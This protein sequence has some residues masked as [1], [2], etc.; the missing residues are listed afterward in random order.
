MRR[1]RFVLV[2]VL[3]AAAA[4]GWRWTSLEPSNERAW[5]PQQARL[6]L[7]DFADSSVRVRGIRNFAY[8]AADSFTAGYYDRSYD[9]R[10]LES[11]WF[12]VVPFSKRWRGPAH[13]FVSFGFS[14]SQYV[15]ISVEARR[16]MGETY[17]TLAGLFRRYELMYVVGD[18]RDVIG[19]R[20][21]F[22]ADDVY[23]YPIR[24]PA[25]SVRR[26]FVEMLQR[27]NRLH[28]APEF[29]NTLTNS[30]TSNVVRHVNRVAPGRVPAG[31]KTILPGYSDEVAL[32]LGLIDTELD[33]AGA[34]RRFQIN[35]RARRYLADSAFSLRIREAAPGSTH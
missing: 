35:A 18:E 1:S 19:Q 14:D 34:R 28:E 22:G 33:L 12:I 25:A 10:R 13:T 16:E 15:A 23:L 11:A 20:A 30:C 26:V 29:Y 31:I 6:A 24:A 2:V 21:A 8:V 27:V 3:G 32:K 5:V 9:L 17:G 4:A 7:A